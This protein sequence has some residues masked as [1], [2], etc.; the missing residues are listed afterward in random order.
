M[1]QD[2]NPLHEPEGR[3]RVSANAG[4]Y[5]FYGI[6]VSQ[7]DF[8]IVLV[9]P[10]FQKPSPAQI[11]V[12]IEKK[13]YQLC[14]EGSEYLPSI[15]RARSPVLMNNVDEIGMVSGL[16][17]AMVADRIA[18]GAHDTRVARDPAQ[19]RRY[20]RLRDRDERD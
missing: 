9:E 13:P 6:I 15:R 7:N 3:E 5:P 2:T 8:R 4:R 16:V 14:I 1:I 12:R 18:D 17:D 19:E 10:G 20:E 11:E